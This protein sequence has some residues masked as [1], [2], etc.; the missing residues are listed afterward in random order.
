M[1]QFRPLPWMTAFT[2][3]ALALLIALGTWQLRR[4]DLKRDAIAAYE[5]RE[6]GVAYDDILT[7]FCIIR[8]GYIGRLVSVP[9]DVVGER[10]R[11]YG[12]RGDG[13]VG[14]RILRLTPAPDCDC[15]EGGPAGPNGS[16][17]SPDRYMVVEVDF[18]TLSGDILGAPAALQIGSAPQPNSFTAQNDRVRGEYYRYDTAE[19][20]QAFGVPENAIGEDGWLSAYVPGLPPGLARMPPVR[21]IGYALT[22]YGLA[23]TLVG[24]YLAY[25]V[26]AG[27][28]RFPKR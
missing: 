21:H 22:W 2:L 11:F 28:L 17:Y 8:A 9:D 12:A 3:V 16:C 19:L 7:P 4:A 25:H 13:P 23:L 27:R 15:A 26:Q 6:T 24:V 14:W 10:V 1:I 5:A 20:A 18:E